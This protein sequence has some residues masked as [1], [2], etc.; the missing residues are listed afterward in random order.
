MLFSLV[1]A[2]YYLRVIKLM[3]FDEPAANTPV[4]GAS[5]DVRLVFSVNGLTILAL[6]ILP[7]T[8]MS[9]CLTAMLAYGA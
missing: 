6:G 1:G 7:G 3:Y 2:F 5:E 4:S 8:L 9:V